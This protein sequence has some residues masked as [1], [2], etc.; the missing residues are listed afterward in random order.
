MTYVKTIL[1]AG[2]AGFIGSNLCQRLVENNK[3]ICVDNL[4]T[5]SV[6]NIENLFNFIQNSLNL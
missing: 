5:G 1:I 4:C 3:I 2:G 6:L